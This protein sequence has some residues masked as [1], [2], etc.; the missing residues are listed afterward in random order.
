[1]TVSYFPLKRPYLSFGPLKSQSSF[2]SFVSSNYPDN[3]PART[4][5][6]LLRPAQ[7]FA[8]GLGVEAAVIVRVVNHY[9]GADGVEEK[10]VIEVP[11]GYFRIGGYAFVKGG[12]ETV[13]HPDLERSAPHIGLRGLIVV[14]RG[15]EK[16][17][18]DT[19]GHLPYT[20]GIASLDEPEH[21]PEAPFRRGFAQQ[22]GDRIGIK[23]PVAAPI[24]EAASPL[25]ARASVSAPE[26]KDIVAPGAFQHTGQ[27]VGT[28]SQ[29]NITQVLCAQ[30]RSPVIPH[31]PLPQSDTLTTP[32]CGLAG[33]LAISSSIIR[34]MS[35]SL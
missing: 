21:L 31:S 5:I 9:M 22:P 20:S 11:E 25:I 7:V 19:F 12:R 32:G 1:M 33:L 14:G 4:G 18:R 15:D 10:P 28:F 2:W 34:M 8:E 24:Q 3:P 23:L 27:P 35:S 29:K 30:R 6:Q 26:D 17:S 16:H 13:A